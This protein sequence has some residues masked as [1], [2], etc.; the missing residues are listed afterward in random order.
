MDSF[1]GRLFTLY[2]EYNVANITPNGRGL[3]CE[4]RARSHV[5]PSF[6]MR[7][8]HGNLLAPPILDQRPLLMP[9]R[10]QGPYGTCTAEAAV[11]KV[12]HQLR[13]AAVRVDHPKSPAYNYYFSGEIE[14]DTSDRGRDPHNAQRAAELYGIPDDSWCPYYPSSA[15]GVRPSNSAIRAGLRRR[16]LSGYEVPVNESSVLNALAGGYSLDIAM[17]VWSS[18]ESSQ[19]ATTGVIPLPQAGES[20]LGGHDMYIAGYN[21]TYISTDIPANCLLLRNSWGTDFGGHGGYL[22]LPLSALSAIDPSG[23]P[24][25]M[26][27]LAVESVTL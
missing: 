4:L 7:A 26:C 24:L 8:L 11:A 13:M 21:L 27:I 3:G 5:L 14:G 2:K 9:V 12:E 22:F 20:F 19:V 15:M 1:I 17:Y 16:V 23:R 6:S 18:F 25:V 10:N